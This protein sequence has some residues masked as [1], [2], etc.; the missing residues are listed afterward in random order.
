MVNQEQLAGNTRSALVYQVSM[1]KTYAFVRAQCLKNN[2][3]CMVRQITAVMSRKEER[4]RYAQQ[5]F[6]SVRSL[7]GV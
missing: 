1:K 5:S 4:E 7:N 2:C 3:F 6:F